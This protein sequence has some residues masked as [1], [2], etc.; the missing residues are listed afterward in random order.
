MPGPGGPS[1]PAAGGSPG[2]ESDYRDS[3]ATVTVTGGPGRTPTRSQSR[4]RTQTDCQCRGRTASSDS[5][6]DGQPS[7]A[8]LDSAARFRAARG[9]GH[10][11]ISL[12]AVTGDSPAESP[13]LGSL[14]VS[15][16]SLARRQATVE[17]PEADRSSCQ[18]R[19]ERRPSDSGASAPAAAAELGLKFKF[20]VPDSGFSAQPEGPAGPAGPMARRW[21]RRASEL[22]CILTVTVNLG[23][24]RGTAGALRGILI[25]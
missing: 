25:A 12:A 14:L 1:R 13:R 15:L 16:S 2:S 19:S 4:T 21:A 11:G 5:E 6:S 22:D 3:L 20:I 18:S 17:E 24:G 10:G 9:H 23:T 7:L 8:E